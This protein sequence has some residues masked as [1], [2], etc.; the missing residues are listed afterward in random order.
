MMDNDNYDLPTIAIEQHNVKTCKSPQFYVPWGFLLK[1]F[2]LFCKKGFTLS[3][4]E[5]IIYL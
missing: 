4:V 3:W 1:K 5:Y 2:K